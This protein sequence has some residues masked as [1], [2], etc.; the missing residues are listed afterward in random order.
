MR[1]VTQQQVTRAITL[2][3]ALIP[4]LPTLYMC[5]PIRTMLSGEEYYTDEKT[6]A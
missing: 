6:E 2:Y 4:L 5:S 1:S 3:Q